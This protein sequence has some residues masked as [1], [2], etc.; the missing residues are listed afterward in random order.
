[1]KSM[2]HDRT[3]AERV[4][5]SAVFMTFAH[6]L[7]SSETAT[8]AASTRSRTQI[9]TGCGRSPCARPARS[10][11][12]IGHERDPDPDLGRRCHRRH[13]HRRYCTCFQKFPRSDIQYLPNN[14]DTALASGNFHATSF[15]CLCSALRAGVNGRVSPPEVG[16]NPPFWQGGV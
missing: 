16:G 6:R 1:M 13:P 11:R 12:G 9:P 4:S 15:C 7:R 10:S 8:T 14:S 3:S 5:S 2:P